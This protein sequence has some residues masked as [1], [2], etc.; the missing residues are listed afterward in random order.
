MGYNLKDTGLVIYEPCGKQLMRRE[1]GF[2]APS[3]HARSLFRFLWGASTFWQPLTNSVVGHPTL[4]LAR[5][6]SERQCDRREGT[7]VGRARLF[8]PM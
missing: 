1:N 3:H 8:I 6:T 5:V 4:Y 2:G 7:Y